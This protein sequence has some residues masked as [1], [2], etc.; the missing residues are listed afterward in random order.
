MLAILTEQCRARNIATISAVEASWEDDWSTRGIGEHEVAIA[1]RSLVTDDL[2]GSIRKL[3]AHATKR[4]YISTI[5]GDGPFDRRLFEATGKP[6]DTGPDY[7][8]NYNLLYQMGIHANVSFITERR[9]RSYDGVDEAMAG[10]AWMFDE[11]TPG[12]EAKLRRHMEA[13]LVGTPD[14]K[15]RLSYENVVRWAV[16]WWDWAELGM[17]R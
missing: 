1:S 4:V 3:A 15:W 10:V 12:E 16:I 11:L 2:R 5:V 9:N 7:I 14:G 6:L 8:Y 17:E 13:H